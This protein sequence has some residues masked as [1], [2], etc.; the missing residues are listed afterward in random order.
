[1]ASAVEVLVIS[2]SMGSG[3]TTILAEASDLLTGADIPHAAID[4]DGLSLGH[5]LVP[6]CDDLAYRNLA[7]IWRNYAAAG[8][9][10]LLIG[11]AID[12]P[13]K[14]ERIRNAIPG[15]VLVVC[16]LRGRIETMRERVREREPGMLQREL[17]DRVAELEAALDASALDDFS[18]VNDGRSVTVVAREMLERAGWI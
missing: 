12:G 5:W 7:A 4:L 11:E 18:V 9:P 8:I 15:G 3:K 2:G 6:G 1:M 16:R 17:V 13:D 10:R 14:L